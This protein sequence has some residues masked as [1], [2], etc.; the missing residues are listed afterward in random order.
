LNVLA[1]VVRKPMAQI[2]SE[3][4]GKKLNHH[5]SFIGILMYLPRLCR[6]P[7]CAGQRCAQADGSD[8]QRV[9]RQE[10]QPPHIIHWHPDVFALTVQAA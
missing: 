5:T 3:F 8:L 4:S 2:F 6:P 10:A 1:N 7:E 9:Q